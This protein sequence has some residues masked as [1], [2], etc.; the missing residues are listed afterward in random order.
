MEK[1]VRTASL[2]RGRIRTG[3]ETIEKREEER[4]RWKF[5]LSLSLVLCLIDSV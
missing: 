5:F 4:E 2:R 1:R 3:E